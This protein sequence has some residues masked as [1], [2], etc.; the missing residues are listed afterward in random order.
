MG[1]GL[2]AS[3][4]EV[5]VLAFT[6]L[7]VVASLVFWWAGPGRGPA[8]RWLGVLGPRAWFRVVMIAALGDVRSWS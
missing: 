4:K 7:L 6:A 8:P 5:T 3:V 2:S 1:H